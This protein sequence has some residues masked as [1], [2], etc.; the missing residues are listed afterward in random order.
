MDGLGLLR[1][2]VERGM[3]L[4]VRDTRTSDPYV[5]IECA[6]QKVK[7]RV[8]KDNCNPVWN[9]E[10]TIL[11]KDI[12]TPITIS[13]FDHDKFSRD[14]SMG[15]AKIDIK[16]FVECVEMGLQDLPDGTQLGR[17]E[18][19]NENCLSKESCIVWNK[20]KVVQEMVLRLGGVEC[21]EL[22]IQIE[23]LHL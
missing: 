2:R 21:G 8:E 17:M 4:A 22:H 18:A 10:L 11:I 6:S 23:W 13:V 7:T 1:I 20:G 12:N 19:S 14:D 5:V 9:E 3:N 16:R 15:S